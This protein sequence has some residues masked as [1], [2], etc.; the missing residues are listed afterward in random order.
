MARAYSQ[1]LRDRVIDAGT[2]ARAAAEW[3]GIGSPPRSCGC[4]GRARAS[5]S[6][7]SKVSPGARCP[8]RTKTNLLGLI[9]AKSDLTIA[10]LQERLWIE[11]GVSGSVARSGAS[12]TGQA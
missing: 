9:A 7:A 12:W 4:A 2:S 5:G 10:E 3:F 11:A 1:E 8:I 6:H